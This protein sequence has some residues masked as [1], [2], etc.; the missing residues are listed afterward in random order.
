MTPEEVFDGGES[1]DRLGCA[2]L[3][4]AFDIVHRVLRY[5]AL[6]DEEVDERV[7]GAGDLVVVID[8]GLKGELHVGL[9]G[10]DPDFADEDVV[11]GDGVDG[12][13]EGTGGG[14]RLEPGGPF[15]VGGGFGGDALTL[16][17]DV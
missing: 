11:D 14:E 7:I 15:A 8:G 5:E 1:R 13:V 9:A 6:D 3:P 17:V 10:A 12:Q 4:R 16:E 2:D